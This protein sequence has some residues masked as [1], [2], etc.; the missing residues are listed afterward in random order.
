M[1]STL[2][3]WRNCA[4]VRSHATLRVAFA[5]YVH[6][7]RFPQMLCT[8]VSLRLW[9]TETCSE[10]SE[11]NSERDEFTHHSERH[12]DGTVRTMHCIVVRKHCAQVQVS[13]TKRQNEKA[14]INPCSF[15][16]CGLRCANGANAPKCNCTQHFVLCLLAMSTAHD[17][18]KCYALASLFACGSTERWFDTQSVLAVF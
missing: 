5:R 4:C 3:K 13:V 12:S 7:A 9:S 15:W 11:R 17:F 14:R 2:R 10:Q 16:W 6:C 18:R 1:R 8:C